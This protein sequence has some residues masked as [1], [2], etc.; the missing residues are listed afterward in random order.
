MVCHEPHNHP[1]LTFRVNRNGDLSRRRQMSE[2]PRLQ[3]TG[4]KGK[5]RFTRTR[6]RCSTSLPEL[7]TDSDSVTGSTFLMIPFL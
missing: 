6:M 3:V 7:G 5:F 1:F 2:D 4:K